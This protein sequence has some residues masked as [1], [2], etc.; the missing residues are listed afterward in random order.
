MV[1]YPFTHRNGNYQQL[2][3]IS[4]NYIFYIF[5]RWNLLEKGFFCRCFHRSVEPLQKNFLQ[6]KVKEDLKFLLAQITLKYPRKQRETAAAP[7]V[8]AQWACVDHPPLLPVKSWLIWLFATQISRIVMHLLI[9]LNVTNMIQI[10]SLR[11]LSVWKKN[12]QEHPQCWE[13][14]W[15]PRPCWLFIFLILAGSSTMNLFHHIKQSI[16]YSS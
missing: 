15:K 12:Y 4:L 3:V 6:V 13:W 11:H 14:N 2:C 7:K 9:N 1:A 5:Q 10:W 16:Q 8:F